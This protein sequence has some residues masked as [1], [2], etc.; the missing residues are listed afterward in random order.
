MKKLQSKRTQQFEKCRWGTEAETNKNTG[1]V[2][3]A[4]AYPREKKNLKIYF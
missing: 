3:L 2:P 4:Y 1:P